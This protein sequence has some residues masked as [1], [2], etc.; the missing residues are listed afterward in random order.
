MPSL[1]GSFIEITPKDKGR[2]KKTA[3]SSPI[4]T[5]P[6]I[7]QEASYPFLLLYMRVRTSAI[8]SCQVPCS[9]FYSFHD[10]SLQIPLY[11][12]V[13][14]HQGI[15]ALRPPV[16]RGSVYPRRQRVDHRGISVWCKWMLQSKPAF[17]SSCLYHTQNS[18]SYQW[19]VKAK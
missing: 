13:V 5:H 19:K 16:D 1:T 14:R 3:I 9:P 4:M 7:E 11:K 6:W 8:K 2:K 10:G 17:T 18:T 15:T 12:N